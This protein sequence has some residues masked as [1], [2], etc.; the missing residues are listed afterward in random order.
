MKKKKIEKLKETYSSLKP[1]IEKKLKQF[2]KI[3][4]S[5]DEKR[6]FKELLFC[7]LTPQSKAENAWEII[8]ELDK[9]NL[10]LDAKEDILREKLRRVRFRNNKAKYIKNAQAMFIKDG[11]ISIIGKLRKHKNPLEIR[12]WLVDNV[13]GM[14]Y[15]EASHFLRNIG[16]GEEL[17][18]LDRHILR[19]LLELGVI[20]SLPKSLSKK[21]YLETEERM[22]ALAEEVDIPLAHLDFVLWKIQ[23]ERIFK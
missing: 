19:S 13:K 6:I 2:K 9:N 10:L 23:T 5:E 4:D 22:R 16:L 21:N 3:W 8:E 7:L 11:K 20:D 18:I 15:K 12:Q 1:E 17:T 14:G